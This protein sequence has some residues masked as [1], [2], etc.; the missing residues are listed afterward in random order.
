MDSA[1][2]THPM[3][4]ILLLLHCRLAI[5]HTWNCVSC[6]GG[7]SHITLFLFMETGIIVVDVDLGLPREWKEIQDE[8]FSLQ[9]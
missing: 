1:L 2:I 3:Q 6:A 8:H 7:S 4:C 5:T 9:A